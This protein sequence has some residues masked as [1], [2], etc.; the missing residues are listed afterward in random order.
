MARWTE[1]KRETIDAVVDQWRDEC[2]QGDGSLL[3][4]TPL[5]TEANLDRIYER[6]NKN[7][8]TDDRQF[9]EK[10]KEQVGDD[11]DLVHLGAEILGVYFLFTSGV[12]AARKRELI[13]EVLGW[14]G[15]SFDSA[16]PLWQAMAEGI[17]NPGP[18][19]NMAR[20]VQVGFVIDFAR[21]W[22]KEGPARRA[23]LLADPWALRDFIDESEESLREMRHILLHLLRPDEFERIAS[24]PHKHQIA[25]AFADLLTEDAPEDLDERLLA[26]RRRLAE[27]LP[28]GNTRTGEIDFYH[29][30]LAGIWDQ[31]A[32]GGEGLSS[33]A[34]LD[35][36]R[37]LI[38]Y[39]PPGTGKTHRAK[40]LAERVIRHHALRRWKPARY[41][42][43]QERLD[44]LM[45]SH[46]RRLQLHPAYSY[47]EF[48][49]GLRLE[50]ERTAYQNG[51]LLK[52]I[53]EIEREEHPDGEEPLP[54]V[55]I[56]DEINRTDLS[57]LLG[58]A[59]S[60]LEDRESEVELIG[61]E[62]G[63][64]AVKLALPRDL[65]VIGTMNLIDQSVEQIDFALRRRFLWERL[66]F[67]R[68]AIPLVV[69]ARW[70]SRSEFSR[71]YPWEMLEGDIERLADHAALLNR[72][73]AGSDY[74]G[75]QYEIGHTYFFD[76]DAFIAGW[77]RL[78]AKTRTSRFL[79]KK[80]GQ[81]L[82]PLE[83]L[84]ERSLQPLLEQYL[85]GIDA[86][87]REQ[88]LR[89]LRSVLYAGERQ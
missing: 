46:I 1:H 65:F 52:L 33:L 3:F 9:E 31:S 12:H 14:I 50:G 48:V 34:A 54:W 81:P 88:E 36:K 37:Q 85:A 43:Q 44:E 39:G 6:F 22:K 23:E 69:G 79:W 21:R 68:E 86:Q 63:A 2:L 89:Q 53:D 73:I 70:R 49:R 59:F 29:S 45:L 41:F 74:L 80:S 42:G 24:G 87:A 60:L 18:G 11:P 82:P 66:G 58:E 4:E 26:I 83:D 20:D 61:Q 5:W 78:Q 25:A 57:R 8:L 38:L 55:L 15:G 62:D 71:R 76:V 47:E 7:P 13:G 27:L 30:P 28:K 16:K 51:Y 67:E 17:G 56:L 64:P 40:A 19:F 77:P 10:L 84:W 35:H 72:E 75:S 32:A